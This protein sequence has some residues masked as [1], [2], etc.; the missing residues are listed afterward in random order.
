[1]S[2]H[3][4][5]RVRVRTPEG[6][7]F[8]FALAGPVTRCIAWVIDT[9]AVSAASSLVGMVLQWFVLLSPDWTIA[10]ITL[11]YFVLGTG[12][13]MA[14]EFFWRGQ[15]LGK[16]VMR[17]RVVDAGGLTLTPG[18]IVLRNLIRFIDQIPA[19]Y[20]VGGIAM[21]VTRRAQRLG[22]IVAGTI[23]VRHRVVREP[24]LEALVQGRFNS[25]R[26]TPH[27]AARL[28]QRVPAVLAAAAVDALA[29][30]ES[31]EAEARIALFGELARTFRGLVEFPPH[32]VADLP[33]EALV[34]NVVEL[35][36]SEAARG[37]I[38]QPGASAQPQAAGAG[39][40]GPG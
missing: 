35:V 20:L 31:L 16:R 32:L 12:Y 24:D 37:R 15:T 8:T 22:D 39:G 7:I 11:L 38:A 19:L 33:D 29:R 5:N 14:L 1:M 27:L 3:Q 25:L 30:R 40:S 6:V 9:V 17:L 21:M 23:V 28:R 36:H 2:E 10:L 26:E 34:R 13:S 18:Q 4:V